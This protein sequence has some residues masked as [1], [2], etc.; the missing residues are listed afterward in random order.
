MNEAEILAYQREQFAAKGMSAAEIDRVFGTGAWAYE[1]RV[2]REEAGD[3]Y[4][5]VPG[6]MEQLVTEPQRPIDGYPG[7]LPWEQR[8]EAMITPYIPPILPNGGT[9]MAYNGRALLP[10]SAPTNGVGTLL[11]FTG[12]YD[13]V[14]AGFPLA[15]PAVLLS[16]AGLR[17]LITTGAAVSLGFIRALI[18][19]VGWPSIALVVGTSLAAKILAMLNDNAS[20]MAEVLSAHHAGVKIV[21]RWIANDTQFWMDSAG[22]MYAEKR[23]GVIKRWKPIKPIC[24]VRGKTRLATAVKAQRYL[25]RLWRTVA[26]RTKALKLA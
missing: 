20:D 6:G 13:V 15:L 5:F 23:N 25:D 1:T 12:G 24:L 22:Y 21:K 19:R 9:S 10:G 17:Y 11:P 16:I 7:P 4:P 3:P 14:Q 8:Q 2:S 18:A 26:K